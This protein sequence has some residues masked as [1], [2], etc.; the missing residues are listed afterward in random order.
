MW[1]PYHKSTFFNKRKSYNDR[2]NYISSDGDEY[3]TIDDILL[4]EP[5]TKKI[6]NELKITASSLEIGHSSMQ[7]YRKVMEDKHIISDFSRLLDHSLVAVMDGHSGAGA[8]ILMS[9]RLLDVIEKTEYWV[10]YES[11]KVSDRA[12][13][14]DLISRSLVQAMIDMDEEL[15]LSPITVSKPYR[16]NIIFNILLSLQILMCFTMFA[17]SYR[18]G[19]D[20]HVSVQ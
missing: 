8:A 18:M 15:R 16:V 2:E 7:G 17:C 3:L 20:V 19:Q 11:L 13:N 12:N 14:V 9:E 1:S 6:D 5:N 4:S 10:E